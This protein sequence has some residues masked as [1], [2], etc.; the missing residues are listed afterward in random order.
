MLNKKKKRIEMIEDWNDSEYCLMAVRKNPLNLEFV[1]NQTT[2][3]CLEAV[4][5]D[6]YAL[7][8]VKNQTFEM[9]I[10]SVVVKRDECALKYALKFVKEQTPEICLEAIK[11]TG[12]A[13]KFVKEQTSEMCLEAIK[14]TGFALKF[15]K[16]QT[17][18]IIHYLKKYH[19]SLYSVFKKK[20]RIAISENEMKKFYNENPHLLLTL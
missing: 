1:K 11:E 17:P 14:E 2:E 3:I 16:E 13:L 9:C 7:E 18:L 4:K 12:F 8:F 19:R 6:G 10:E 20:N 15:V 5:R